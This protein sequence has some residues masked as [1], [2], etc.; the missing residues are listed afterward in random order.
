MS[1]FSAWRTTK[2]TRLNCKRKKTKPISLNTALLEIKVLRLVINQAVKLGMVQ[3]NPCVASG[4][5]EGETKLKPELTDSDILTIRKE[6]VT[7][8]EWDE[9][10]LRNRSAYGCRFSE[11]RIKFSDI[12]LKRIRSV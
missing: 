7:R 9:S 10:V 5:C 4:R 1:R 11:T 6:L 12:D 3:V 2:D 8:P